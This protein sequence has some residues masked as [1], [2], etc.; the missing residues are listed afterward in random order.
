MEPSSTQASYFQA[1]GIGPDI[2]RGKGR[3][4]RQTVYSVDLAVSSVIKELFTGI[5]KKPKCRSSNRRGSY[6]IHWT[7]PVRNRDFRLWIQ[8]R[9]CLIQHPDCFAILR[10]SD[11]VQLRHQRRILYSTKQFLCMRSQLQPIMPV[12][13]T[14]LH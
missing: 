3:H 14:I 12:A 5:E 9:L 1:D 6:S 10:S 8:C 11:I 2:N 4:G 13:N 7:P